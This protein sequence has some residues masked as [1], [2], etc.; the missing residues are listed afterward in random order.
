MKSRILLLVLSYIFC[1]TA[2]AQTF[3]TTR[4]FDVSVY[5]AKDSVFTDTTAT[6]LIEVENGK[7]KKLCLFPLGNDKSVTYR[8]VQLKQET[9][10]ADYDALVE[11]IRYVREKFPEWGLQAKSDGTKKQVRKFEFPMPFPKFQG[12][13][14]FARHEWYNDS[15]DFVPTFFVTNGLLYVGM[16]VKTLSVYKPYDISRHGIIGGVV[17]GVSNNGVDK[18]NV[19]SFYL[20]FTKV[21]QLDSFL[22]SITYI[23]CP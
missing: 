8:H 21:E 4:K 22:K 1:L 14:R 19:S 13:F 10:D 12:T 7:L 5:N 3:K 20:W 17:H 9:I 6:V 11:N 15:F 2:T 18:T 16:V 23:S